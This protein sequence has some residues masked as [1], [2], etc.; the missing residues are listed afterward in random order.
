MHHCQT[1]KTNER[2]IIKPTTTANERHD[3]VPTSPNQTY[4]KANNGNEK[5]S[6]TSLTAHWTYIQHETRNDANG[7]NQ[8]CPYIHPRLFPEQSQSKERKYRPS[9]TLALSRR[10]SIFMKTNL[11]AGKKM[12]MA[13][14]SSMIPTFTLSMEGGGCMPI[15][16]QGAN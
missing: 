6:I 8:P 5:T 4:L 11:F 16:I 2:T 12:R 13:T 15:A 14:L 7:T 10:Q 9:S 3:N 1:N